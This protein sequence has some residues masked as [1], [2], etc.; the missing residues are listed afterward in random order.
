VYGITIRCPYTGVLDYEFRVQKASRDA[1]ATTTT[2]CIRAPQQPSIT[3]V[4]AHPS[5]N[6]I[7]QINLNPPNTNYAQSPRKKRPYLWSGSYFALT[8]SNFAA[9]SAPQTAFAKSGSARSAKLS[10]AA[11]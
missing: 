10:S 1:R 2:T 4:Y 9:V 11:E 3:S 7:F 5:I 8:S 6:T